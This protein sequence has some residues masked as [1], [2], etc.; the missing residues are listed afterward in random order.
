MVNQDIEVELVDEEED[1]TEE[2][3]FSIGDV[4]E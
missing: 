2:D 1:L 3:A 4:V